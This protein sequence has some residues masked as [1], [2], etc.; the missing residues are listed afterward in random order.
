MAT[1]LLSQDF[2]RWLGDVPVSEVE[3]EG[4]VFVFYLSP[5]ESGRV[6]AFPASV[7]RRTGM[8]LPISAAVRM[9][10]RL[11]MPRSQFINL[12]HRD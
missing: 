6:W 3:Q 9:A 5:H 1:Q 8:L 4:W 11:C 12:I 10:E 2:R 7:S